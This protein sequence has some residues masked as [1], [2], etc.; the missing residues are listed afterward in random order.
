ML[1]NTQIRNHFIFSYFLP[2]LLW[3]TSC[4]RWRQHTNAA[5]ADLV[6]LERPLPAAR[7]WGLLLVT[8]APCPPAFL[9]IIVGTLWTL[10]G[11]GT[12]LHNLCIPAHA[13]H[14]AGIQ[15]L[16]NNSLGGR[17]KHRVPAEMCMSLRLCASRNTFSS[18]ILFFFSY[19]LHSIFTCVC[20]RCTASWWN[21]RI[22]YKVVPQYLSTQ[23]APHRMITVSLPKHFYKLPSH[24]SSEI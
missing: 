13:Q 5:A 17:R 18:L 12:C 15:I 16:M 21:N 23:L 14:I 10:R 8:M 4:I 3:V 24:P 11:Q 2:F 7:C 20:F 1:Q 19:S 22:L 6:S 9:S